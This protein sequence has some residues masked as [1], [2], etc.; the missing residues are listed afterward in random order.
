MPIIRKYGIGLV[1]TAQARAEM[2]R[3][4]IM[5]GHTEKMSS[6]ISTRHYVEYFIQ[7][8]KDMTADGRKNI[9]GEE[10]VNKDATDLAGKG[11]RSGFKV[12]FKC[13]KSSLGVDGRSG[14][15]QWNFEKGIVAKNEEVF[16]L[17]TN[18][19]I[20]SKPTVQ[21]YEFKGNNW[22]GKEAI[23]CALRDNEELYLDVLNQIKLRD[24][25]KR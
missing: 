12:R 3:I 11:E 23:V 17:A 20:I 14:E 19:G 15:F 4:E 10:F 9:L 1:C 21:S 2:D 25:V 5:R 6:A 13:D 18:L 7:V 22:R 24:L 8:N 16:E